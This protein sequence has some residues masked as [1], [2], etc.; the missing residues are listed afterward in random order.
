MDK[1][2]KKEL[3]VQ[4]EVPNEVAIV[5]EE[6][7]VS[8]EES[9]TQEAPEATEPAAP[10]ARERAIALLKERNPDREYGEEDD[11]ME[12]LIA[13][14]EDDRGYRHKAN[15]VNKRLVELME[16]EPVL[17]N[18][19]QDALNG[20]PGTVAIARNI[21]Q[22]DYEAALADEST[23]DWEENMKKRS[24]TLAAKRKAAEEA[25]LNMS[26]SIATAKKFAEK[27]GLTEEQTDEFL[28]TVDETL[29]PILMGKISEA[30][31][32]NV[33]KAANYEK[34]IAQAEAVTEARVRNE[35]IVAEQEPASADMPP[36]LDSATTP[37]EQPPKR[38]GY[39]D[40][41]RS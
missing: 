36:R 25:E 28:Q 35:K 7:T 33:Y 39:I 5:P 40:R 18:I 8:P 27:N 6:E 21:S 41:L 16:A 37:E 3:E 38:P 10:S 32:E 31:L 11:L 13:A 24:E 1:D 12:D 26:E 17:Y 4:E 30:F 19:I 2:E 15:E 14:A 23:G 29:E 9:A 22:E 20:A 34:D